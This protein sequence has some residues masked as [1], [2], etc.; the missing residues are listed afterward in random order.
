MIS[1]VSLTPAMRVTTVQIRSLVRRHSG[2]TMNHCMR[3]CFWSS[4]ND[5]SQIAIINSVIEHKTRQ[6]ASLGKLSPSKTDEFSE[7]FQT[8]YDPP[9]PPSFSESYVAN[10]LNWLRSLHKLPEPYIFLKALGTA[11]FKMYLVLIFINTIVEKHNLK[12][13][14]C[15]NFMV[16]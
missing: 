1:R 13:P 10:F 5:M 9:P 11:F 6:L 15:I 7:K 8:A 12:R 3:F 14:L 2:S 4:Q 16:K